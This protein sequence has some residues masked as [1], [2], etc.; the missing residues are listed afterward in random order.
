M[1]LTGWNM[2]SRLTTSVLGQIGAGEVE[3]LEVLVRPGYFDGDDAAAGAAT[4]AVAVTV[5]GGACGHQARGDGFSDLG[6]LSSSSLIEL[7][8]SAA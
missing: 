2:R 8:R 4:A 3:P 6:A 7:K 5:G 1:G